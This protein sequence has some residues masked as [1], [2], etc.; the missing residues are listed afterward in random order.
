VS[1][2]EQFLSAVRK[3]APEH[4]S[5]LDRLAFTHQDEPLRALLELGQKNLMSHVRLSQLWA[6]SLGVAYVNPF[7]VELPTDPSIQLASSVARQ[8]RALVLTCVG[9][10]ATVGMATPDNTAL[11]DSLRKLIGRE[12]S[13][14]F[15]HPDELDAS[16]ELLYSN[17]GQL[18]GSLDKLCQEITGL[19]GAR[20][21]RNAKEAAELVHSLPVQ[22]LFNSV[23][24]TAFRRRASDIHLEPG[25]D[26]ARVR[27]RVD[28]DMVE[29]LR[30]P[31]AVHDAL[32]VRVKVLSQLDVAQSRL[33]QDGAFEMN[34]GGNRPAFRTSTM[35]TLYGEKAVVRLLGTPMGG[36]PIPHIGMLGLSDS[37]RAGLRRVILSPNGMLIVCGPTGSGKTTTLYACLNEMNRPDLNLVTIEDPVE[38][39]LPGVTQHPV[40]SSIGLSFSRILRGILRQDPDVILVG[41]IRD[42]ETAKIATEA[43]LTG[44]FVMTSLHA[45]NSLEAVTRLIEIGVDSY[46]VAPTTLAVLSQRLVRRICPSCKESY[47]A[48]P[49]DLEPFFHN[50]A[51][52]P[53]TL[54]R[55]RGCAK[56]HSSGFLGRIGLHELVEISST[57]RDLI[58]RDAPHLQIYQEARRVGYHSLR[59]D[60]LKKALLG[61]TTL[62]E[63]VLATLPELES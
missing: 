10:S 12:I 52:I 47:P 27:F 15:S 50:P 32:V 11:L 46:L 35:P 42:L 31:R 37:V 26:E 55:G 28:G 18:Q 34:F 51:A 48:T 63:V 7:N 3:L 40:N 36:T 53:V 29:I 14:V 30:L 21:I 6:D 44:H 19:P 23:V 54:Y 49:A 61:Y 25:P 56:C 33:P 17:E 1:P 43:A 59:Y 58:S 62:D 9:D 13:P 20:E 57:M 2:F 24:V 45:N 8:A 4:S 60:G 22:E 39:R 16:I 38:I 5:L 41:E